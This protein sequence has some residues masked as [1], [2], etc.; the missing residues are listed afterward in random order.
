VLAAMAASAPRRAGAEFSDA[1][2]AAASEGQCAAEGLCAAAVESDT[3]TPSPS[4]GRG[5]SEPCEDGGR[6]AAEGC[7]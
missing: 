7:P 5:K 6:G 2:C 3:N 4:E 1:R